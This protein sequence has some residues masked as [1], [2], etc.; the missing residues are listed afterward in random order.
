[1]AVC[2]TVTAAEYYR[3]DEGKGKNNAFSLF[4]FGASARIY[5]KCIYLSDAAFVTAGA[6][7]DGAVHMFS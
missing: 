7:D 3:S 6:D 1:M 5:I 4:L 2:F